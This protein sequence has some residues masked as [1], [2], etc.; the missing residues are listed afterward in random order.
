[1]GFFIMKYLLNG[2]HIVV[3]MA[4]EYISIHFLPIFRRIF[5]SFKK[6]DEGEYLLKLRTKNCVQNICYVNIKVTFKIFD[7]EL[8]LHY[9]L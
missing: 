6:G 5:Q 7:F 9:I 4:L 1:M 3:V 8:Y 2:K